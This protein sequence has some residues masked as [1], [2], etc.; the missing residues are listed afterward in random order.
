MRRDSRLLPS[1]LGGA[2]VGA[3]LERQPSYALRGAEPARELTC[4]ELQ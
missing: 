1:L 2:G 3:Q 4:F